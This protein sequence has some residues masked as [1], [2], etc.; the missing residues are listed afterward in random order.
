MEKEERKKNKELEE[1]KGKLAKCEERA[2]PTDKCNCTSG[3]N[4]THIVQSVCCSREKDNETKPG[5]LRYQRD[6]EQCKDKA[7]EFFKQTMK[8][9]KD[10]NI[11]D[12]F[13]IGKGDNRPLL[14]QLTDA[15]DKGIIYKHAKNLKDEKN[16]DDT[17]Y[18]VKDQLSEELHFEHQ[19]KQDIVRYNKT[20]ITGQQQTIEWKKGTWSS[21]V[22]SIKGK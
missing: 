6:K 18:F 1:M 20:L 19:R 13:W 4:H 15:V 9:E 8:I 10:I 16:E 3:P 21:M 14:V 17:S 12:A 2:A 22:I 7:Q 11:K 5:N